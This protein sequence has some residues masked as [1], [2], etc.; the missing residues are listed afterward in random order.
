MLALTREQKD[1]PNKDTIG[2]SALIASNAVVW[3]LKGN[4]S[5]YICE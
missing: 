1:L 2:N 3:A 4:V 5:K